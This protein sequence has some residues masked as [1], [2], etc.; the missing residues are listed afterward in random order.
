MKQKTHD[1]SMAKS[2]ALHDEIREIYGYIE[3]C[4]SG[5]TVTTESLEGLDRAFEVASQRLKA[6]QSELSRLTSLKAQAE[7]R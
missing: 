6:A 4:G 2:G 5:I 1:G 7:D 3:A